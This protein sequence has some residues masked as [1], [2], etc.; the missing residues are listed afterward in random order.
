MIDKQDYD[1]N[2]AIDMDLIERLESGI[3]SFGVTR[4][5]VAA[6][7]KLSTDEAISK[8]AQANNKTI[9]AF[10][11]FA[12]DS[13]PMLEH[14]ETYYECLKAGQARLLNALSKNGHLEIPQ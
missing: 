1:P 3:K 13:F 12:E 14:F 9:E 8:M 11:V 4:R 5:G 10:M 2:A 6:I 7:L